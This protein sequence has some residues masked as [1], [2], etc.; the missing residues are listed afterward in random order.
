MNEMTPSSKPYHHGDL[1]NALLVEAERL[2]ETGGLPGLTLRAL[3]RNVGVTHAAPANH[4]GDLTGLLSDLA[5][6]GH[7]RMRAE[8]AEAVGAAGDDPIER[9]HAMGRAY[10]A[11][12]NAHPGLFTLM[13]R[14]ER[15]DAQRPALKQ[16][17]EMTRQALRNLLLGRPGHDALPPD[18]R[19]AQAIAS[20]S[21]VHGYAVLMLE[22]RLKGFLAALSEP[23]AP[24]EFFSSVLSAMKLS[25]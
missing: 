8:L 14:S 24:V 9:A 2:L 10:V 4:F 21:L 22:G 16:A 12:A 1:R 13:F 11:F 3:A 23:K 25:S 6:D 19:V 20:W 15:L 5:A 18:V 17:L 7:R